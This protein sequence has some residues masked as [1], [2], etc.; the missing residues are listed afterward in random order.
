MQQ[1]PSRMQQNQSP[2]QQNQNAQPFGFMRQ[3]SYFSMG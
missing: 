1:K 3:I 2:A